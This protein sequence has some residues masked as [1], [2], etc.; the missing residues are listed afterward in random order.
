MKVAAPCHDTSCLSFAIFDVAILAWFK[1][2]RSLVS[3]PEERAKP[4]SCSPRPPL[5]FPRYCRGAEASRAFRDG[6]L[7]RGL[8]LLPE[9]GGAADVHRTLATQLLLNRPV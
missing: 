8:E 1:L 2:L 3:R 7:V 5:F 6:D 4:R 9:E